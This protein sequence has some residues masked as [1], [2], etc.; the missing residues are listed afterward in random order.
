MNYRI[1]TIIRYKEQIL[2][3]I[4]DMDNKSTASLVID[5]LIE[6]VLGVVEMSKEEAMNMILDNKLL[7]DQTE[8]YDDRRES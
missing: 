3:L 4:P 1:K 2:E 8:I 7:I 6:K 5:E